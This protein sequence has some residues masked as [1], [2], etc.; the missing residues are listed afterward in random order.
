MFRKTLLSLSHK[1]WLFIL[2][3]LISLLS[4]CAPQSRPLE[5]TSVK[6]SPEPVVGQIVTLEVKVQ[7][8]FDQSGVTFTAD[9]LEEHGNQVHLIS[10]DSHW[11]GSLTANQPQT[12]TVTV[13]VLEEGTWPVD[14]EVYSFP[15]GYDGLTDAERIHLESTLESGNLILP[16]DYTFSQEEYA[17][18]PTPRSFE[19]P[20]ECSGKS[21]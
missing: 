2:L 17:N 6:V 14:F 4:A 1:N 16:K 15:P 7:S 18:R 5:I 8:T 9:T 11:E 12:F 20:A 21:R 13:C 3:V 10:G 19:V